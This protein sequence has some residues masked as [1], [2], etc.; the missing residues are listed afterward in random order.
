MEP[1]PAERLDWAAQIQRG[2]A[3]E[4]LFWPLSGFTIAISEPTIK[5]LGTERVM[6]RVGLVVAAAAVIGVSLGGCSGMPDWMTPSMPDWLSSQPPGPQTQTLQFQSDP[7]GAEVRTVQGQTCFTP[8]AI[9]V[10]SQPQAVTISK[11]GFV[12]Q[13][14]QVSVGPVPDHSFWESAP[15][16]VMVPN[17]VQ[18]VLQ[19]VPPPPRRFIKHKPRHSVSRTR[20]AARTPPPA[21]NNVFPD[22]PPAQTSGSP[23]PPPP[24]MQP[25]GSPFPPPPSTQ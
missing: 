1:G 13:T 20:T 3:A 7:P 25:A 8:C 14:I 16:P 23:F 10:L 2:R 24:A 9:A 6:S 4:F 12:A 18:V 21:G 22:P 5:R 19:A 17:P 15:P 11:E